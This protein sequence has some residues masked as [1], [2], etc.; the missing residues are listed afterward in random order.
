MEAH[1]TPSNIDVHSEDSE[2]D[3][4]SRSDAV[5]TRADAPSGAP[6]LEPTEG[7]LAARFAGVVGPNHPIRV[8]LAAILGGYALLVALTIAAGFLLTEVLL[9]IGAVASADERIS[10][11]LERERTGTLVD[12]SW[13]GSTLAGG[14]VIPALVGALLV[15][16]LVLRHWRLAAFTLFVICVESG[17]YRATTLVVHRDRPDVERLEGLPVE[18]S[19]PS[20]HTAASVALFGGLL[21]VLASRI[22][23]TTLKVLLWI[24][25]LAIPAFVI[26]SRMLRGMHHGTDVTAGVLMGLGALVVVVFAARAAGAASEH[27]DSMATKGGAS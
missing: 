9:S 15:L 18:A 26:W 24:A 16:F 20:G 23:N 27:R 13:L 6:M 21:L 19:F 1:V 10:R 3:E 4:L 11:W 2:L 14:V 12:L 7:G 17:T 22:Q 8:F 25:A 5:A